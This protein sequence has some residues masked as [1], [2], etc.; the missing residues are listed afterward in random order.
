MQALSTFFFSI[1]KRIARVAC[2]DFIERKSS[3]SCARLVGKLLMA[4]ATSDI[5]VRRALTSVSRDTTSEVHTPYGASAAL[6][7]SAGV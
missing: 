4:S 1:R 7:A 3:R 5:D 2:G 6:D